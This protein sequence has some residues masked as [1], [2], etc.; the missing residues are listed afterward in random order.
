MKKIFL[1][2]ILTFNLVVSFSQGDTPCTA[3]TLT[4]ATS[5]SYSAGTNVGSTSGLDG[6][7]T[8]SC[9]S[10]SSSPDV[11][12][13]FV[14]PS[15]GTVTI[16]TTSGTLTDS[17]MSLYS[18]TNCSTGPSEI[19][20]DD[21][22]GAGT[23][24]EISAS[25]LTSGN[26]YYIRIWDYNDGTGTFNICITK[27][28]DPPANDDP[29]NATSLTVNTSC[30][31]T[32]GTN[33]SATASSGVPAPGCASYVSGDVWYKIVVPASGSVKVNTNTGGVTDSGMAIYSGACG[34][35]TLISCDDDS[36]PNGSMSMITLTGQSVGATLY[37]RFWAYNNAQSGTFSI[38]ATSINACGNEAD[39]DYCSNPATLTQGGAGWTASTS[40]IFTSDVPDNLGSVFCGSIE[41]NS[42]YKF[43]ASSTTETFNFTSVYNCTGA[44]GIQAEVFS[45]TASG[46]GCCS[47]FASKSNCW[48]P[49]TPTSGTVTAT[50]LTIGNQYYLMVD[51]Y[52]GDACSFDVSG[53]SASGILP[54]KLLYFKGV[55]ENNTNLLSWATGVEINNDYFTV[56]RSY[57]GVNFEEIA[58]IKGSGN[59]VVT[60]E[61]WYED[62]VSRAG[63]VYYRLSQTDYNGHKEFTKIISLNEE[64]TIESRILIY[65]NPAKD[66]FIVEIKEDENLG[67]SL[68][69]F[70]Q[71]GKSIDSKILE[72]KDNNI[73]FDVRNIAKGMYLLKYINSNQEIYYSEIAVN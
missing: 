69:L 9:A 3:T 26:T 12:Y 33:V 71:L 40:S 21:D 66:Y 50:G 46:D 36:S 18:A 13:K 57:D 11:W 59:T 41:N 67:G 5:C 16:T 1:L 37:V 31:Y 56:L 53:W 20:C 25:G 39:N 35:L 62:I 58:H 55:S 8:P 43:T 73:I 61:Y 23:M 22:S 51:G 64:F 32:S 63:I 49:G 34:S 48:N 68:E 29:C 24:S 60:K 28:A 10:Y 45:L 30:S 65:P 19:T 42:W 14:A 38:C 4:P 17:G 27:P 2:W 15:S 44:S 54:V 7:G 52:G 70:N 6:F 47:S 72:G